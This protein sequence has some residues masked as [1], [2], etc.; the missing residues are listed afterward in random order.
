MKEYSD[1]GLNTLIEA[2]KEATFKLN[3]LKS[4]KRDHRIKALLAF[5]R[6]QLH[7]IRKR[8]TELSLTEADFND[9]HCYIT[10]KSKL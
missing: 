4:K 3:L 5:R 10:D 9:I 7:L 2:G 6:N 8:A 1:A